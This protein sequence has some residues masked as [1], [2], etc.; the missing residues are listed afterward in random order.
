MGFRINLSYRLGKMSVEG[1][2]PRRTRS[3]NNDDLKDGGGDSGGMDA[4]GGQPQQQR[5]GGGFGQGGNGGGARG[6]AAAAAIKLPA[7]DSTAVVNPEGTWQY[8]IESPQ[9]GEG[10]L[11]ITK[12]GDAYSGSITNKK[13]NSNTPL[14]SVALKGNE[15]SFAYE[16]TG[17]G[18]N[19]M[20]VQVKAIIAEDN[21]NGS[22]TVGQFGTFP[23]KA[24]RD[25]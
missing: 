5:A 1:P 6:Q 21:L 2:R 12:N 17:Q 16:V 11:S 22:M 4:G 20:P 15:L 8:T 14:S 10:T 19:T 13:F 23:I 18:G 24:K 9:G 3:I 25:R 7:T